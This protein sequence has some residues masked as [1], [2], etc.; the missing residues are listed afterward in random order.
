MTEYTETEIDTGKK[1][2]DIYAWDIYFGGTDGFVPGTNNNLLPPSITS[3]PENDPNLFFVKYCIHWF[4]TKC[5]KKCRISPEDI[6]VKYVVLSNV[7]EASMR[8][9]L[10]PNACCVVCPTSQ[11]YQS[12]PGGLATS[13]TTGTHIYICFNIPSTKI[14][15]SIPKVFNKYSRSTCIESVKGKIKSKSCIYSLGKQ[16]RCTIPEQQGL[17]ILS[18]HRAITNV[19]FDIE[20]N[21]ENPCKKD[22]NNITYYTSVISLNGSFANRLVLNPSGLPEYNDNGPA[23]NFYLSLK[24]LCP[25]IQKILCANPNISVNINDKTINLLNYTGWET[26]S[27]LMWENNEGDCCL[28]DKLLKYK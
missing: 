27:V 23:T 7:E 15:I 8:P 26:S 20:D 24:F 11:D 12:T 17:P 16:S 10:P 13:Y 14:I 2:C 5:S 1:D 28:K 6:S 19:S 22:P 3:T 4:T 25:N 18:K 21:I 9:P